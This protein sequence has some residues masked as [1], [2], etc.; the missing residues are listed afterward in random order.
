FVLTAGGGSNGRIDANTSA[1]GIKG[2]TTVTIGGGTFT[3][4]SADDAVHSNGGIVVNGG[5][6]AIATGDD[7]MHA[8]ATLQVNGGDIKI[9]KSYEGLES[10]VITINDGTIRIVS[11]DDGLNGAGG[12]DGSGIAPGP[13]F[14]GARGARPPG[15]DTFAAAAKYWLYIRGGYIVIEAVGDG[16]D[17][18]GSIEMT[19][20]VVIVNGPI[21]R[22]NSALDYDATFK[23][24]GGFLVAAG[25]SGMAQAPD[26]S[27]TQY[28]LLLNTTTTQ[29]A[30]DL[31]HIRSSDGKSLLTFAPT[32][33][34]QSIAFSSPELVKG[35]TYEVYFG[36]SSTGTVKDGVYQNGT[37]SPGTKNTSFTTSSVVTRIGVTRFR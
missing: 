32:K 13:G 35:T 28:A 11:S 31:V 30:G 8:D 4:D 7:G 9:T 29:R 23:L 6:F 15:Q 12:N 17:I 25:S 36:G 24:T 2:V 21:V 20:G 14:G 33:E 22:M 1:K 34:Y 19:N 10:A 27:S 5:A 3:I 16:I 18:N 26:D 37:Y